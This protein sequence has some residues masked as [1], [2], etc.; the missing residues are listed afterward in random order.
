M[1]ITS[2]PTLPA[3][4]DST[5]TYS[6]H[7][8]VLFN[9]IIY[10]SVIDNNRNHS[11]LTDDSNQYWEP[12]AIYTKDATVMEHGTNSGDESLWER[13]NIYINDAGWVFINNVNTGINVRG[14]DGKIKWAELTNEEKAEVVKLLGDIVKGEK[15]DTGEKGDPGEKGDTG[16]PGDP[17]KDGLSAFE[18]WKIWYEK[19]NATESDF[20][21]YLAEQVK[22]SYIDKELKENSSNPVENQAVYAEFQRIIKDYQTQIDNLVKRVSDLENRLQYTDKDNNIYYFRFGV[23]DKDKFYGYYKN[24]T[25][26]I[27]PFEGIERNSYGTYFTSQFSFQDMKTADANGINTKTFTELPTKYS[28]IDENNIYGTAVTYQ[29]LGDK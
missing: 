9:K 20:Y 25:D 17:G 21:K 15:G 11:P 18:E 7:E 24:N 13:D 16:R 10:Y 5:K 27:Y 3:G 8:T 1:A 19:P 29:Q 14:A 4:W 26:T 22:L 28:K 2:N 23:T 6:K 12:L